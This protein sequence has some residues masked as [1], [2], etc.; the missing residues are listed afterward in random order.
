MKIEIIKFGKATTTEA[1]GLV[2]MYETR[3]RAFAKVSGLE[4]KAPTVSSVAKILENDK[5][6]ALDERG[7]QW[8]SED[9]AQRLKRWTDDPRVKSLSFVIGGPY[10]LDQKI[11][12][13]AHETWALSHATLPSD[14][15]WVLVWEQ[16]YRA[17]NILKGTAYHHGG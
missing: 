9:L 17:F 11:K 14:L 2:K 12:E 6:I 7:A 4:I 5:V 13:R 8:S 16:V 3:L 15:A 1:V 10:G